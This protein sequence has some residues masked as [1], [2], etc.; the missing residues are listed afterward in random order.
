MLKG[1]FEDLYLTLN[2]AAGVMRRG[3]RMAYIVGNARYSGVNIDVDR[4]LAAIGE[5]IGLNLEKI[6]VLRYRGNSAQQMGKYGREKS[7]ESIVIFRTD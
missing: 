5:Q 7:R 6:I 3:A 2:S 4:I 1:Y